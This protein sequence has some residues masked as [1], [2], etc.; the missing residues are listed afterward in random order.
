VGS[1]TARERET[2]SLMC[3]G[4]DDA[5]I[6]VAMGVSRNTVRNNVARIYAKL[7]VNR[8][9]AAIIWARE[10]GFPLPSSRAAPLEKR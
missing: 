7:G 3:E 2:L 6:A 1:L 5:G 4:Q 9:G 8:R 10:R